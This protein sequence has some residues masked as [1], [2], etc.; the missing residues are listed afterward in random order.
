MSIKAFVPGALV[1]GALLAVGLLF[2]ALPAQVPA[3]AQAKDP[4]KMAGAM[5]RAVEA[6]RMAFEAGRIPRRLYAKAS[7]TFEGMV[8]L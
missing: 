7:T 1:P 6:G 4:V 2:G 5:C 8:E 3:M